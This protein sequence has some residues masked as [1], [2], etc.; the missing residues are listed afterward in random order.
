VTCLCADVDDFSSSKGKNIFFGK[1]SSKA[2]KDACEVASV[3]FSCKRSH[4][5]K[6]FC[7]WTMKNFL[8]STKASYTHTKKCQ[9]TAI[10]WRMQLQFSSTHIAHIY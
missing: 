4:H 2:K 7:F 8:I 1:L 5:T 10:L 6:D 3:F 9:G